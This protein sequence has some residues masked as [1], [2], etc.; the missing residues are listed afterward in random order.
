MNRSIVLIAAAAALGLSSCASTS[1]PA[2]MTSTQASAARTGAAVSVKTVGGSAQ[3]NLGAAGVTNE[4]F[5]QALEASLVQSGLFR[6][7]GTGGY[8][9]EAFIIKLN[10]PAMGF[11]MTTDVEIDYVLRRGGST[12]WRESIKSTY[13]ATVGEAFVGAERVRVST[14]G[15]VRENIRTAIS[16]MSAKLR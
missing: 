5:K 7:V 1:R 15:A 2:E 14:E 16:K 6:G 12:V 11:N 3:S 10:Q 13:T 8:S 4:N 9:L